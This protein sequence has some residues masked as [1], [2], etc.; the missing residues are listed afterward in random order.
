MTINISFM[1]IQE[2]SREI[3]AILHRKDTGMLHTHVVDHHLL[4][5]QVSSVAA[6]ICA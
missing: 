1:H 5:L 2:K 3:V 6:A 4:S